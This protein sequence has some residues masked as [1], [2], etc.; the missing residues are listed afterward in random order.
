MAT[1][2]E[3]IK[4]GVEAVSAPVRDLFFKLGGPFC[5]EIGESLRYPGMYLRTALGVRFFRRTQ[6][7]IEDAGFDPKTVSPKIFLP[8]LQNASLENCED[9][10]ER[11]AALLANAA[12]PVSRTEVLPA[13]IEFLK[14]LTGPEAA[15]LDRVYDEVMEDDAKRKHPANQDNIALQLSSGLVRTETLIGANQIV[16]DNLRRLG[17]LGPHPFAE[18]FAVGN[19]MRT[20]SLTELGRAFVEA[21]HAP[22][23]REPEAVTRK[24]I[25]E[26]LWCKTE[27]SSQIRL[28]PGQPRQ[29]PLFNHVF[30]GHGWDGIDAHWRANHAH[31][32]QYEAFWR[33]LCDRHRD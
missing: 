23:K 9:L 10:Q 28:E 12:N 27:G 25:S 17:I 4:L 5:E 30:Q 14:Q 33:G 20:Y 1:P 6:R 21:C 31:V 15:F 32:A 2:G 13:F 3:L 16:L 19:P 8:I 11:W 18:Q 29:C 7:M 24:C 22:S 26:C